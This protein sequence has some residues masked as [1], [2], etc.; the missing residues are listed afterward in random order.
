MTIVHFSV[1]K[2]NETKEKIWFELETYVGKSVAMS[3]NM[4]PGGSIMLGKL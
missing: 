4:L 2:V 1:I 3:F